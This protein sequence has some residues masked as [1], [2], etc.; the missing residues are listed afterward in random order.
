MSY[1]LIVGTLILAGAPVAFGA[2]LRAQ[3]TDC[4]DV[5]GVWIVDLD[6]PGSGQSQVTL[7]LEQTDCE[8]TGLVEGH[9]TTAIEN[10]KVEG[11]TATFTAKARNQGGSGGELMVA[12]EATV[13]G[14]DII[15]T[16]GSQM[17]GTFEFTGT[18]GESPGR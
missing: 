10:G 7:T 13:D 1:R 11:S 4:E 8:V 2:E 6:L 3:S 18:R 14:D 5:S 9:N 12:W 17:M 16:L 15:G